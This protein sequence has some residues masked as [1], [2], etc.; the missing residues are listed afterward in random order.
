MQRR[1]LVIAIYDPR[2]FMNVIKLL[3][4]RGVIFHHYYSRN[5]VPGG[6]VLY[7]DLEQIVNEISDRRDLLVIYDPAKS[8]RKLEEAILATMYISEYRSIVIGVDPGQL[9]SYVVLGDETLVF[10]GEGGIRDF[11][12]DLNYILYCIPFKEIRIKVGAGWR[13]SEIIEFV[14]SKYKQIPLELVDE[15]STSPSRSRIDEVIYSSKRLR[16]LKPFR[17]KDIYAAYRIALSKGIE[18]L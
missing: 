13:S 2:W 4:K 10:Y 5:E 7:T 15:A 8:C 18:V 12:K 1:P 9:I 3:K 11:E 14:K 17:Y 16:G 6:S